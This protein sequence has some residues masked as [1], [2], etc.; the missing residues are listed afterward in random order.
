LGRGTIG[1][2][3]RTTGDGSALVLIEPGD[4]RSPRRARAGAWNESREGS[5]T[6][7]EK[8]MRASFLILSLLLTL[9]L[10]P[11]AAQAAPL[12]QP[13]RGLFREGSAIS[14]DGV[15]IH[16]LV[17]GDG[18][19]ALVFVHCWSCNASYWK[20]QMSAFASRYRVVAVDLAGHG[21]SGRERKAWTIPAFGA[22]VAAVADALNLKR[23]V[24]VGHSMGGAVM[25]EA[26]RLL[27]DRVVLLVGADTLHDIG[28]QVSPE[29]LA[30]L[31]GGM[32]KDFKGFT[33][34]FVR[35]MFPP[36]V[37]RELVERVANGMASAPPE[38]AIAAFRALWSYDA[39]PVC[40]GLAVPIVCI[41]ADKYPTKV[42]EN[43]AYAK[44]FSLL[45]MKGAGHFVQLE[46][47][48]EFNILLDRTLAER[49]LD[50]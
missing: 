2:D 25:L 6:S 7:K 36:G 26:A 37:D 17:A 42:E 5:V 15:P 50:R 46:R 28:E 49:G 13:S 34:G 44:D 10:L 29:Q 9:G 14:A 20:A 48:A 47:P 43:R 11:A 1:C 12:V 38:I 18:P 24:I 22:D 32:E 45:L 30:G 21:T 31:V 35:S 41:N 19:T 16:Y 23:I 40:R 33:A 8:S 39:R 3:G 27:G 4:G